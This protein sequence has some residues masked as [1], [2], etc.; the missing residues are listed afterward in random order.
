MKM[1]LILN[2]L[3]KVTFNLDFLNELLYISSASSSVISSSK[4]SREFSDIKFTIL[5]SNSPNNFSISLS[6]FNVNFFAIL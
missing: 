3:F 1:K 6:N 5:L 2:F 4:K